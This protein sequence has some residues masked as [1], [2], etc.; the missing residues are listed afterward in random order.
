MQHTFIHLVEKNQKPY[1]EGVIHNIIDAG[2]TLEGERNFAR[3]KF[4]KLLDIADAHEILNY[5]EAVEFEGIVLFWEKQQVE[6]FIKC[7]YTADQANALGKFKR[8][9]Q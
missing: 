3:E 2:D 1:T 5:E 6:H 4:V 7:G 9:H 8:E